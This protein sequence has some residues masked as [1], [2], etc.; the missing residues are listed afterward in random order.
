MDNVWRGNP[1]SSHITPQ[2]M[3]ISF[4]RAFS[5]ANSHPELVCSPIAMPVP[6]LR[7]VCSGLF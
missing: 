5:A 2:Y 1:E 7:I 4:M 6:E 3:S